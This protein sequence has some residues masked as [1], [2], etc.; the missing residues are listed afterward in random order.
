[1]KY[2]CKK[3]KLAITKQ[4]FDYSKKYF[5]KPLCR[6]CQPTPEAKKLGY[7]LKN[8]GWFVEFEKYDG[9]K[10]IDLA[11]VDAKVNI[12]VDGSHHNLKPEQALA[13]LKKV[14]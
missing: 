3:C 4:E 10:S 6:R 12:E 2:F 5:F 1:M 14:F 11:I 7:L 13:D 9:Y 8:K